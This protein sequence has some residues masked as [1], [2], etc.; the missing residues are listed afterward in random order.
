MDLGI[1]LLFELQNQCDLF[2]K[3]LKDEEL[4]EKENRQ[5][6]RERDWTE[7][8]TTGRQKLGRRMAKER[9]LTERKHAF[10]R[11]LGCKQ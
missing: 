3:L 1:G 4:V 7:S 9:K 10:L 8:E 11:G 6:Q 5:H 2:Q